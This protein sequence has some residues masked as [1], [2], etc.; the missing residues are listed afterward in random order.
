MEDEPPDTRLFV[1]GL[2]PNFTDNDLGKHFAGR[3]QITDAQVIPGRRIGFV[4][5]RNYT[6]ARNAVAYFDKSYIRLSKIHVEFAK[7]MHQMGE[8]G[9]KRKHKSSDSVRNL[10][11]SSVNPAKAPTSSSSGRAVAEPSPS[12]HLESKNASF[13]PY[14]PITKS[15]SLK[16]KSAAIESSEKEDSAIPENSKSK[17][18]IGEETN[19]KHLSL[20]SREK[21][22]KG[23]SENSTED[24]SEVST[25]LKERQVPDERE[26]TAGKKK[27]KDKKEK[28]KRQSSQEELQ[29]GGVDILREQ[30]SSVT[31]H[32]ADGDQPNKPTDDEW[33]RSRTL[34]TLGLDDQ[35]TTEKDSDHALIQDTHPFPLSNEDS[36]NTDVNGAAVDLAP[37]PK[38]ENG[39]LFLRNLPFDATEQD[40]ERAFS[41]F[42]KLNE[43]HLVREADSE[44]SKGFAYVQFHN[45]ESAAQAKS[46]MDGKSFQGR[47]LHVLMAS[48]KRQSATDDYNLSKLPLKKQ[49]LL[50]RKA[51]LTRSSSSWNFLYMSADA[52]MASVAERLGVNK[53]DILDPTSSDAAVKQAHA[54]TH[55]I[56]E[57]QAFFAANGINLKSFEHGEKGG[58][59]LL[60]KNFPYGTKVEDLR[61]LLEEHGKVE[62]ILMPPS[63]II[64][65]AEFLENRHAQSALKQLA[66]KN[67]RG[68]I[69]FLEKAPRDLFALADASSKP[70]QLD[71][72]SRTE[73]HMEGPPESSTLFIRNLNFSTT[74]ADLVDFCSSLDGFLTA[75]VKTKVNPK[76]PAETL[77]MGFGF[78]DFRSPSQAHAAL[79]ALNG[80]RLDGH[81]LVVRFA[82]RNLEATD[83]QRNKNQVTSPKTKI[84]IKNLPFEATK[85][86]VRALFGPYGQ[87]RSVRVPKKFDRSTRGFAFADFITS[88]EAENALSALKDT[89]LLGRRLVLEFAAE[90]SV[91]P[92]AE[93]Q[94]I[95][96]KVGVQTEAINLR[97]AA[98]QGRRKFDP[99]A[100][101]EAD[102]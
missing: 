26:D 59:S 80:Y 89:H 38:N 40:I 1:S 43:V 31:L 13:Q 33:L 39:R 19:G 90:E 83:A 35:E 74:A 37:D 15:A 101:D 72:Q 62:R 85:K 98:G 30:T 28:R 36:L 66:Y 87:L 32:E 73:P 10:Q 24:P 53:S 64:A 2:P 58:K 63:G 86:D 65:I 84:I 34:R 41:R 17:T 91:D 76:R 57:N 18:E 22:R 6:L 42:G 88:K 16:R 3:Y 92:E 75:K 25:V 71:D 29:K 56:Q 27:K 49:K 48:D 69:L 5:F 70:Q 4:G 52:V 68:S 7:P 93:I 97:K 20:K 47:L 96:K 94:A 79:K 77:S 99:N 78:A 8:D 95:E 102:R 81:D 55:V 67:F 12:D 45:A 44:A 23:T 61:A 46:A 11:S 100:Q 9:A 50:K 54:E 82:Q 60:I 21:R 14:T 51:D